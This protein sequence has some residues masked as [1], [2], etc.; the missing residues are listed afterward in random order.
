M[1]TRPR[2][3]VCSS[4]TEVTV[5]RIEFG[6]APSRLTAHHQRAALARPHRVDEL[7][8]HRA[9]TAPAPQPAHA[10]PPLGILALRPVL[11]IHSTPAGYGDSAVKT[12][13]RRRGLP[14]HL[15]RRL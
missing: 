11:R 4:V 2:C 10:A 12:T 5:L 15:H 8:Q 13:R 7:I 6:L 1:S 14:G 9:F 3:P